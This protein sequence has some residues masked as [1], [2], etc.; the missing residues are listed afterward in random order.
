MKFSSNKSSSLAAVEIY[1][2]E[3]RERL[4]TKAL[5]PFFG[6]VADENFPLSPS[7]HHASEYWEKKLLYEYF[8][9]NIDYNFMEHILKS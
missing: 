8:T 1:Q 5:K 3:S 4:M 7:K 9:V 2:F 6:D